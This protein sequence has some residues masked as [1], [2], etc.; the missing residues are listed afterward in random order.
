[1]ERCNISEADGVR[2]GMVQ[3]L[4]EDDAVEVRELQIDPYHQG[5]G[6]GTSV[7]LEV[8]SHASAQGRDVRLSIGL[9]NEKA[10]R[11]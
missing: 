5:Q 3:L 10:I 1:M 8:I 4:E 11:F 7:L 6:I 2:V 9:K